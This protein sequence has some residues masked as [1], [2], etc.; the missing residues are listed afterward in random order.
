MLSPVN[1]I[2][3]QGVAGYPEGWIG[4][5]RPAHRGPMVSVM[6]F[7]IGLSYHSREVENRSSIF[8]CYYLSG[9]IRVHVFDSYAKGGPSWV[10]FLNHY[11]KWYA[12][13]DLILISPVIPMYVPIV[14]FFGR[15]KLDYQFLCCRRIA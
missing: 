2:C 13:R 4:A 9:H 12:D 10:D 6:V 14:S 1:R 15:P 7:E 5:F 11:F 8:V 3:G